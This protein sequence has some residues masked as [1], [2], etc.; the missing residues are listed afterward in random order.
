MDEVVGIEA[1][2]AQVV[3]EDLEGGE[4][5]D[6]GVFFGEL[7]G[8]E[9]Q[10][11]LADGV[12]FESVG[13]VADR[14]HR[15]EE[16]PADERSCEQAV[17]GRDDLVRRQAAPHELRRGLSVAVGHDDAFAFEDPSRAE[18]HRDHAG[19]AERFGTSRRASFIAASASSGVG[20]ERSPWNP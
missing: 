11:G 3:V 10:H 17:E 7:L 20:A 1:V 9:P 12:A 18:G 5:G 4:V 16:L 19:R 15:E 2:V 6:V 13:E 8:R 14:A